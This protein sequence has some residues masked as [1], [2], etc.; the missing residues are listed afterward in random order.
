MKNAV[1][2]LLK[3]KKVGTSVYSWPM[4]RNH[5]AGFCLFLLKES[6]L[7]SSKTMAIAI[8]VISVKIK[9]PMAKMAA[10]I[11]ISARDGL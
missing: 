4:V 10:A 5:E 3:V 1:L 6:M 8:L 7:K 9:K 11:L 2:I